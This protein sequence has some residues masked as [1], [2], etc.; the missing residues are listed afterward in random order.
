MAVRRD[1]TIV[2]TVGGGQPE[3]R[4]REE[5]RA[6]IAEGRHASIRVEMRGAEAAGP[7]LICGG[8]VE[9]WIEFLAGTASSRLYSAAAAAVDRG[10]AVVIASSAGA[11]CV[12]VLGDDGRVL[13]GSGK[14]LDPSAVSR[15]RESGLPVL[16]G[17]GLLY[18]PVEGPDRLLVLGGGHV[19]LA[20]AQAADALSF[21]T[22]VAD[23]RPEYSDPL[24]FPSGV[25]CLNLEF[26]EAI[27]GFPFGPS[28]YVVIVS[29]GHLGDLECARAVLTKEYR[30]AGFIGSRR[31]CRMIIEELIAEGLSREKAEALRAPIGLDIGAETPEE[32]AVAIAAELIAVRRNSVSLAWIDA[33]RKRR[34]AT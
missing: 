13:A 30:Y 33:D 23:P 5:A 31:K 3:A 21:K 26:S 7:E 12:A 14:G 27:E 20:L 18:A 16:S 4:A 34:R 29:P 28:A 11:G 17:D 24:R 8:L 2:G 32:I 10:V 15:A 25:E 19:G 22:T 9:I 1:G 6:C